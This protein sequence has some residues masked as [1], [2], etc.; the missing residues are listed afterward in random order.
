MVPKRVIEV[1]RNQFPHIIWIEA[2]GGAAELDENEKQPA[3]VLASLPRPPMLADAGI[4][5]NVGEDA[6]REHRCTP[7]VAVEE[8]VSQVERDVPKGDLPDRAGQGS[9]SGGARA[10]NVVAVFFVEDLEI[11]LESAKRSPGFRLNS[12]VACELHNHTRD[13]VVKK[14]GDTIKLGFFSNYP[15]LSLLET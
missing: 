3:A 2:V 1:G 7:W 4:E 13:R 8:F 12:C 6:A 5:D 9:A 10:P 11:N 15:I 14:D